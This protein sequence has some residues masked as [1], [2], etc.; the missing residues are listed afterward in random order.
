ME[1]VTVCFTFVELLGKCRLDTESSGFWLFL[2]FPL[3]NWGEELFSP[4][5]LDPM[6]DLDCW[7]FPWKEVYV[8][9]ADEND[10]VYYFNVNIIS[11][12]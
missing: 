3:G 5:S 2:S 6:V 11:T 1:A 10:K 12:F 9:I 7:S 4:V 8:I